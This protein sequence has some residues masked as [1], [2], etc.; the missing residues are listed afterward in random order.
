LHA[1]PR[2]SR[3]EPPINSRAAHWPRLYT[4]VRAGPSCGSTLPASLSNDAPPANFP[5]LWRLPLT[6]WRAPVPFLGESG[7]TGDS[8]LGDRDLV[9]D[10]GFGRAR[11]RAV[12]LVPF[13]SGKGDGGSIMSFALVPFRSGK[14][15]SDSFFSDGDLA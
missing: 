13:R 10:V 4:N 9:G 12:A 3:S 11:L 14:G 7:C 8:V 5:A 2:A 1:R 15:D 6:R